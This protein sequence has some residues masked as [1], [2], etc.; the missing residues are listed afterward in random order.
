MKKEI[1]TKGQREYYE[2]LKADFESKSIMAPFFSAYFAKWNHPIPLPTG[3]PKPPKIQYIE[4]FSTTTS[5]S[6]RSSSALTMEMIDN[7]INNLM[8]PPDIGPFMFERPARSLMDIVFEYDP[9]WGDA[10][11]W[12]SPF[13]RERR[14]KKESEQKYL[15]M[16]L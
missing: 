8:S 15:E 6:E 2:T 14:E 11:F 16:F 7:A 9:F 1:L 3:D 10:S 4:P 5:N 13:E 12:D